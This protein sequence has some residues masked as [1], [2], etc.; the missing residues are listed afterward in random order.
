M[1]PIPITIITIHQQQTRHPDCP[2]PVVHHYGLVYAGGHVCIY[3][4]GVDSHVVWHL[5]G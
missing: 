2:W 1:Y 4:E 3:M 5:A